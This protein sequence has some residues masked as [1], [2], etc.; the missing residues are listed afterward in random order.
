MWPCLFTRKF[1]IIDFNIESEKKLS[2][3]CAFN[4]AIKWTVEFEMR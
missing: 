1:V 4:K 2:R 3:E